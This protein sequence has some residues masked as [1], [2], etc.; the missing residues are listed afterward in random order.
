MCVLVVRLRQG[1]LH[2]QVCWPRGRDGQIFEEKVFSGTF[3]DDGSVNVMLCGKYPVTILPGD[4]GSEVHSLLPVMRTLQNAPLL[5]QKHALKICPSVSNA[6][7]TEDAEHIA[8]DAES[9]LRAWHPQNESATVVEMIETMWKASQGRPATSFGK[10]ELTLQWIDGPLRDPNFHFDPQM[11]LLQPGLYHGKY[12]VPEY[13]KFQSETVI[14][15][16]RQYSLPSE[17]TENDNVWKTIAKEIFL[18]DQVR[19]AGS[20]CGDIRAKIS[21][22]KSCTC[23]VFVVG[24]KVTGDLH[25]CSGKRTFVAVVHP[26]I[27]E[28]AS[29]EDQPKVGDFLRERGGTSTHV[30]RRKWLGCGALAY[31]GYSNPTW[32]HGTLVQLDLIAADDTSSTRNSTLVA[33]RRDSFGFMWSRDR[34]QAHASVMILRKFSQH[35]DLLR[36]K[37]PH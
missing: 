7:A 12:S 9:F 17:S 10:G 15:E 33:Q 18:D 27:V 3:S 14:L 29:E 36:K 5:T 21:S 8:E 23:V 4:V 20:L 2:G 26:Q 30:V 22:L 16:Y 6:T 34:L 19:G 1:E 25:V 13:G 24:T 28:C 11:P 32:D 35:D 31:A 37:K